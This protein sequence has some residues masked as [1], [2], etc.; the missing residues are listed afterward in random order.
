[1]FSLWK[2]PCDVSGGCWVSLLWAFVFV[3]DTMLHIQ[4]DSESLLTFRLTCCPFMDAG[5]RHMVSGS[6]PDDDCSKALAGWQQAKW[7]QNGPVPAWVMERVQ[8]HVSPTELAAWRGVQ[9]HVS[10]CGEKFS[11]QRICCFIASS[12]PT[13]LSLGGDITS[14]GKIASCRTHTEMTVELRT[15]YFKAQRSVRL[16]KPQQILNKDG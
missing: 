6:V 14:N 7:A 9:T 2:I 1:M 12:K 16:V 8:A 3:D 10:W 11:T 4:E 15:F 5:R 13:L